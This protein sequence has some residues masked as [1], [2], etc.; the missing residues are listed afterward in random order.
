MQLRKTR[1]G[2]VAPPDL[3]AGP[4]AAA[5]DAPTTEALAPASSPPPSPSAGDDAIRHALEA[6]RRAETIDQAERQRLALEQHIDSLE[7]SAHKKA[8]LRRHPEALIDHAL[9]QAMAFSYQRALSDGVPDDSDAMDE[10]IIAG[11]REMETERARQ[12]EAAA[13]NARQ[14]ASGA[15]Y[16]PAMP[17]PLLPTPA[18]TPPTATASPRQHIPMAAPVSRTAPS[19][20]GRRD[21]GRITLSP[22]ERDVARTSMSW[23]PPEQAEREY[24]N[25]KAKL[26]RM[27]DQ[28]IYPERERG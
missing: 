25:N 22:E 14:A 15:S 19:A 12:I 11:M 3:A 9:A 10:R 4:M 16:E 17:R 18:P 7:L 21:P 6:T 2:A 20:S 27:R 23:L 24:A 1:S 5:R 8:F 26:A 28:G 13:A